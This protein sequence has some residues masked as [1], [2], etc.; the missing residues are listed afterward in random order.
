MKK[1]LALTA[2]LSLLT[3]VGSAWAGSVKGTV[4]Y[5]GQVPNFKP[6]QMSGDPVCMSHHTEPVMP[7]VLVLGEGNAVANILVS[8]VN[9]PSGD[10]A[11]PAEPAVL[12]QQGCQ[13]HPHVLGLRVGQD[14][15]ILNPDGTLHNVHAIP[16]ENAEF[17]MAMPKFRKEAVKSFDTAEPTP[18]PFKCD[19]HPW[20]T[21]WVAV[22]D[23]PFFAVTG[24]DGQFEISGLA[25]GEYE[26]QAWHEKLGV[27]T[28]KVT[29]GEDAAVVDF[30]FA[31]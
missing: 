21:A 18:F 23:H 9:V 15:K 12:D 30:T 5:D 20:M 2:T 1:T 14:L 6:I 13:Y 4:V 8:V 22:F 7:E 16:K 3:V 25:P 24:K 10:Y 17:N 29:V 26:I 27:R 31:R 28:A 19:V 11:A